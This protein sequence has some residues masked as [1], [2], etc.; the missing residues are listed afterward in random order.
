VMEVLR[1]YAPKIESAIEGMQVITPQDLETDYGLSEG[2][3][4]HGELA[5]D[6]F[7]FMRPAPGWAQYRTP[8][9][10]LYLCGAGA[11]PGGGAMGAAGRN[12]AREI[13]KDKHSAQ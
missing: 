9:E 5:L 6:Q 11:H 1:E 8:V 7:F 4:Y 2:A 3:M 10:G 12:A 13:L